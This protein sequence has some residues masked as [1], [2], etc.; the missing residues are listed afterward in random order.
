MPHDL[1]ESEQ[2]SSTAGSSRILCPYWVAHSRHEIHCDWVEDESR[3]IL[4][5][6]H[7]RDRQRQEDVFCAGKWDHCEICRM[8]RQYDDE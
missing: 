2:A 1:S 4:R 6:K 7:S 8:L 5:Y 3:L